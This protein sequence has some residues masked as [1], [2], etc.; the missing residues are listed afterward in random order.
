MPILNYLMVNLKSE[1]FRVFSAKRYI[2]KK[3][4]SLLI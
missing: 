4:K 2:T 1:V 3:N